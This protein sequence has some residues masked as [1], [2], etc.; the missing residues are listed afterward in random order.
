[1]GNH[2]FTI[3]FFVTIISLIVQGMT[4]SWAA[5]KLDLIV[6]EGDKE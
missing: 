1:M 4:L 2:I 5:K 6:D 3:V